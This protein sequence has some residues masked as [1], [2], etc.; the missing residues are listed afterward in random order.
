M[1]L[2]GFSSGLP[3]LLVLGT[4]SFWLREA[5]V[6]R[7]TVGHMAWVALAWGFKWLWAPLVDRLPLPGLTRWLGWRRS[8]LLLAQCVVAAGLTGLA[9]HDPRN[10]LALTAMWAGLIAWSAATQDIALDAWRIEAVEAD[11]QGVMAAAYQAGYRIGMIVAGAGVLWLAAWTAGAAQG[12]VYAAW[13]NAYLVMAALMMVGMFATLWMHEVARERT[14]EVARAAGL[15]A[16]VRWLSGTVAAPFSDF[17]R[18]YRKRALLMLALIACYRIPD[19]VLGVMANVF[20]VDLGYTKAEV[21]MVSKIYGVLM[22]LAGAALGGVLVAR[23]GVRRILWLGVV[24]SSMGNLFYVWLAAR[25]H[26]VHA[27]VWVISADNLMAGIGSSAFIA[28]LSSL[29]NQAYTASQYAVLSSVM[30]LL[31]KFL[32]GFSGDLVNAWGYG[33]F[34]VFTA[35]LGLPVLALLWLVGRA[36]RAGS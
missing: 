7:S 15:P 33:G 4:L 13:R 21:A 32:A 30:L 12:Y 1:L 24:L 22:S 31:P 29:T 11:W 6:N 14:P 19:V 35:M 16:A 10:G 25:G 36:E 27:L 20:Y 5:G 8:W 17:M 28:W 26:D 18:R 3:L 23:F 34:F 2:L 9:L